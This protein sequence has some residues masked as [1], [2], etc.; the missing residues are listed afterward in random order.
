MTTSM[1]LSMFDQPLIRAKISPPHIPDTFVHRPHLTAKVQQGTCGPLTLIAAPAGFGKTYLLMEWALESSL[2]VAWLMIDRQDNNIKRFFCYFIGALQMQAPGLGAKALEFIQDSVDSNLEVGLTL[3]INELF[4]LPNEMALVLDEFQVLENPLI[5]QSVSFLLKY[6][7][8]NLH[9]LISSRSEPD[10]DLAWLRSKGRVVELGA[11]E[12]RFTGDEIEEYFQ[13]STNL[14]LP[15]ETVKGIEEHTGG[16]ITALQ[17]AAIS[18]GNR[19]DPA[20]FLSNLQGRLIGE[21]DYLACFLAEEVLN[22]QPEEIRQFLL[23]TSIL[24]T[25]SG[26]LCE[27]VAYPNVEP[28]YGVRMLNRLEQANLFITSL[29][30]KHEWFRYHTMF[31]D[32]LRQEQGKIH[33]DETPELHKRAALWFEQNGNLADAF[34]HALASQDMSWSADLIERSLEPMMKTGEIS[35]LN[36]WIEKLP[37][38][39]LYQRPNLSLSYAWSLIAARQLQLASYWLDEVRRS[40]HQLE[41]QSDSG[42]NSDGEDSK[43]QRMR[44]LRAGLAICH[45]TLAMLSGDMEQAADLY[46]QASSIL[47]EENGY[48]RSF[49][50][51]DDC[52]SAILS[53]DTQKAIESLRATMRMAR[54]VNNPLVMVIAAGALAD[55][56]AQHGHLS[57]AWETLQRAQCLVQ[58]SDGKPLPLAGL[59]DISLG[60]ILLEQDLL[61]EAGEYLERGYQVTRSMWYLGSLNAVISLTRLYQARG[62]TSQA[63]DTLEEAARLA[64]SAESGEWDDAAVA[65]TAVRLALQRDDLATAELWWKKGGLPELCETIAEEDYPYHVYEYL[66]LTQARFLLIKG[67]A[68]GNPGSIQRASELMKAILPTA[69]R[70]QRVTSQMEILT[71]LAMAQSALGEEGMQQTLLRA[72]ALGEPEGYRR[73]FL[74]EGR[75]LSGLLRQCRSEQQVSGSYFPSLAFINSLLEDIQRADSGEPV[76]SEAAGRKPRPTTTRLED[77]FPISLSAREMEVLR[78]IADGKSNQEIS[79]QLYLAI[80]T[81]KRHAYNIFAKLEV[82][83]RT[84]AVMRARQLGLIA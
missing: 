64:A 35:A 77:G 68:T 17:L 82:C 2:P 71:L 22:R 30:G 48:Q 59:L 57:K 32:F 18:L 14:Q 38:E 66:L 26:P 49:I 37:E 65:A 51:L 7:P 47:P 31:A 50:A 61:D 63:R 72:L 45:A 3:L 39:I 16:W 67:Q 27:A 1:D 76:D 13:Q 24:E 58:G 40:L 9:L 74:D 34:R 43:Q 81:T 44:F 78:L 73:I 70:Y 21:V 23:K 20:T 19:A 10:L 41:K 69:E 29:N 25:L 33:P 4:G 79:S 11:D 83:K 52:L 28:G 84:Q 6:L 54:Q 62:D 75:R 80:N 15:P 42:Q 53:G 12:L 8:P 5:L 56:Q 46:H 60:D 36:Y 55:M